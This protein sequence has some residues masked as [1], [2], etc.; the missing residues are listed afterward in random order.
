FGAKGLSLGRGE[1]IVAVRFPGDAA[2]SGSAYVK[3]ANPGSGYAVCGVAATV[4]VNAGR[5]ERC[6]VAVTGATA[7]AVRLPAVEAA[8]P[9]TAGT[10]DDIA[11][12]AAQVTSVRR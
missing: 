7:T 5:V 3:Q 8:L 6:R 2:G 11:R 12:A 4:T 10:P 9:G 1:L